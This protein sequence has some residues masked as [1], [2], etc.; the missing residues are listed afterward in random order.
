[1]VTAPPPLYNGQGRPG[2]MVG[3]AGIKPATSRSQS[4]RTIWLCYTP[5]KDNCK[6]YLCRCQV[7]FKKFGG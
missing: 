7:L 5:N 4:E 1:M 6:Q 2:F 3:V